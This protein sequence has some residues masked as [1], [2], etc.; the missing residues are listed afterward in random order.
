MLK[1][2]LILGVLA[3][4]FGLLGFTGIAAGFAAVAKVLFALFLIGAAV[5]VILGM[6]LYKAVT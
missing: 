1:W 5:A 2:A 3:V 6:T 4:V